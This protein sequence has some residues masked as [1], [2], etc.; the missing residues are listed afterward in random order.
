MQTNKP[1]EKVSTSKVALWICLGIC[2]ALVAAALILGARDPDPTV[3]TIVYSGVFALPAI[4]VP[5]AYSAYTKKAAAENVIKLQQALDAQ[6]QKKPK[7]KKQDPAL[8]RDAL[9]QALDGFFS[10]T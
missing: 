9:Q 6:N 7:A 8:L 3:R 2:V 5:T 1:R 4:V 10:E